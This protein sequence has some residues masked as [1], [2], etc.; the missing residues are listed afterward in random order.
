MPLFAPDQRDAGQYCLSVNGLYLGWRWP[1][2]PQLNSTQLNNQCFMCC[3]I[4]TVGSRHP[5]YP[6]TRWT[7]YACSV[8]IKEYRRPYRRPIRHHQ[9]K[10]TI[11]TT[12]SFCSAGWLRMSGIFDVY[13]S[14]SIHQKPHHCHH[15]TALCNYCMLARLNVGSQ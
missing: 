3:T 9:R 2:S 6:Y 14:I 1:T 4:S 10:P 13:I 5:M 8:P 12:S 11:A 15:R 7:S